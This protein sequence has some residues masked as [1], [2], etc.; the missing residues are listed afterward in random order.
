MSNLVKIPYGK[1]VKWDASV[2][3][4]PVEG[5]LLIVSWHKHPG[6]FIAGQA[7]EFDI[8][9]AGIADINGSL[10][11]A[12]GDIIIVLPKRESIDIPGLI[13]MFKYR[14]VEDGIKREEFGDED[15]VAVETQDGII[16][17]GQWRK[18]GTT[19]DFYTKY[20]RGWELERN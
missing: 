15:L 14:I 10:L 4:P 2:F 20:L 1:R 11:V 5:A 7:G 17:V 3:L 13:S 8:T 18:V 6:V 12:K 9:T 19:S 16:A